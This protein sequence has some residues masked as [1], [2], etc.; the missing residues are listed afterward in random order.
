MTER[1]SGRRAII[2]GGA[3]G[4]GAATAQLFAAEGAVVVLA[5]LARAAD[6]ASDVIAGIE[7]AGGTAHFVEVE[8]RGRVLRDVERHPVSRPRTST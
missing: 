2:T 7:A 8:H 5:D 3:N 1:L 4:L 6:V